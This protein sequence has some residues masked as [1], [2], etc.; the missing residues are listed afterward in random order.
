MSKCYF[1]KDR[2]L[3]FAQFKQEDNEMNIIQYDLVNKQTQNIKKIDENR[4]PT[5]DGEDD[6]L[7]VNPEAYLTPTLNKVIMNSLGGDG[8]ELYEALFGSPEYVQCLEEMFL[9]MLML[10][11]AW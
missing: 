8:T 4:E 7:D 6:S 1:I 9:G 3:V 11:L 2:D 10:M 5:V